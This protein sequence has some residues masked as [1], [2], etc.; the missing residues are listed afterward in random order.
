MQGHLFIWVEGYL[1][2]HKVGNSGPT[3]HS[4]SFEQGIGGAKLQPDPLGCTLTAIPDA[5]LME[6]LSVISWIAKPTQQADLKTPLLHCSDCLLN[7]KSC[8]QH[9]SEERQRTLELSSLEKRRLAGNLIALCSSVGRGS[10]EGGA[11]LFSSITD[12]RT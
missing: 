2:L 1:A 7:C 9:P 5:G 11:G 6:S 3:K 10:R 8:Y 4:G 12:E